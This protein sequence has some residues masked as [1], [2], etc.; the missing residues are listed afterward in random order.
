VGEGARLGPVD[1]VEIL[2]GG[3]PESTHAGWLVVAGADGTIRASLGE[4]GTVVF[5]RSALKPLVVAAILRAVPDLGATFDD[6]SLAVMAASHQA[7]AEQLRLVSGILERVGAPPDALT[8]RPPGAPAPVALTHGCSGHHAGLLAAAELL[9]GSSEG[10]DRPSHPV[11]LAITEGLAELTGLHPADILVARDGCG[12]VA[13]GMPLH[14]VARGFAFLSDP[15]IA[16]AGWAYALDRVRTAI[17]R[18]PALIGGAREFGSRLMALV[19]GLLVKPGAEGCCAMGMRGTG[20][21]L[22][23]RDGDVTGR[24]TRVV[25]L[26]AAESLGWLT[27]DAAAGISEFGP[28][29][30]VR[31]VAGFVAGEIRPIT[32][33]ID[34]RPPG[35]VSPSRGQAPAC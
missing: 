2:R 28:T 14:A 24:A 32:G 23:I 3:I 15:S 34:L 8:C 18:H 29:I 17:L 7:E 31:D 19:P 33:Q 20:V 25:A 4:A 21:A 5:P 6:A 13:H 27:D 16:L 12:S 10:Y 22:K 1:L 30:T 26:A 9:V 11:Q 35:G